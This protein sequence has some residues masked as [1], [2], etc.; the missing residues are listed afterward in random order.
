MEHGGN[1]S[2]VS[3]DSRSKGSRIAKWIE[4]Y[5]GQITAAQMALALGA[6]SSSDGADGPGFTGPK[7]VCPAEK[8]EI[9]FSVNDKKKG[10][11]PG[12][13]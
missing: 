5:G 1:Q 6:G 2:V 3:M 4:I 11:T 13:G 10:T 9:D 7:D 12:A 8:S